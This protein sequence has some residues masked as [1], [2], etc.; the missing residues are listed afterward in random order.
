MKNKGFTLTEV[1]ITVAI[2]A[3]L[4]GIALPAYNDYII[5]G[6]ITDGLGNLAI[7]RVRIEQF[8]QDQIT[9]AGAPDCNL[10]NASSRSF[11]FQ[12]TVQ[13]AT[14]YTLQA[15]GIGGMAGFNYTIDQAGAMTTVLAG[16][17]AGWVVHTPN[18]CWITRKGGLC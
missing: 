14:Q 2:I 3:I 1:L 7:K 5:R 16:A 11:F 18:T 10:D 12:C 4:A 9:Y 8:Y 6:R 13:G 17:P 15:T